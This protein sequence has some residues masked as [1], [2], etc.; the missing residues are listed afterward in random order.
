MAMP[1]PAGGSHI[2]ESLPT[3]AIVR[4]D[5]LLTDCDVHSKGVERTKGSRGGVP[6][7]VA[8]PSFVYEAC[9]PPFTDEKENNVH[10]NTAHTDADANVRTTSR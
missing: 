6:T 8:Y 10:A 3:V 1:G 2:P 5:G 4:A 9:F 7:L